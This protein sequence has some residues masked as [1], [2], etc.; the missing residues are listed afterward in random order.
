MKQPYAFA[1]LTGAGM[2]EVLASWG[3]MLNTLSSSL[4][5]KMLRASVSCNPS[6]HM[7]PQITQTQTTGEHNAASCKQLIEELSHKKLIFEGNKQSLQTK[8]GFHFLNLPQDIS[9][10]RLFQNFCLWSSCT[11]DSQQDAFNC[12]NG[13]SRAVLQG[14][15][16]LAHASQTLLIWREMKSLNPDTEWQ[17]AL[18]GKGH[19]Q[20]RL[21]LEEPVLQSRIVEQNPRCRTNTNK[22]HGNKTSTVRFMSLAKNKSFHG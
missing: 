18:C 11:T 8:D 21:L 3:L 16:G 15:K 10:Q 2:A 9:Y 1:D 12:G 6:G 7:L 17:Q 22:H 20:A 19:H 14:C 5:E 4:G 13:R